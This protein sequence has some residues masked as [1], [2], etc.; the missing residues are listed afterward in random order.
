MTL[1]RFN[2]LQMLLLPEI[3]TGNSRFIDNFLRKNEECMISISQIHSIIPKFKYS[4]FSNKLGLFFDFENADLPLHLCIHYFC[5]H[6][7]FIKVITEADWSLS[8]N[9]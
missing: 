3:N 4:A 5:E 8:N 2:S 6:D 9:F 1:K 7:I